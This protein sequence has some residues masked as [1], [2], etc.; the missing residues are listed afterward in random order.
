MQRDKRSILAELE[1]I[2]ISIDGFAEGRQPRRFQQRIVLAKLPAFCF[3][4][5][6]I[7]RLK[8]LN[9]NQDGPAMAL[10][11]SAD[12]DRRRICR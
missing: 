7:N 6:Q 2:E 1:L 11:P 3:A 5:G 12:D 9:V 8:F 4:A 10:I